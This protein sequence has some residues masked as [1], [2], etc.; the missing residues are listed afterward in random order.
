[1]IGWGG[2]PD[3]T[4]TELDE[5]GNNVLLMRFMDGDSMSISYQVLRYPGYAVPLTSIY[6]PLPQEAR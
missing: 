4:L 6:P 5:L 3:V 1:M 2:G